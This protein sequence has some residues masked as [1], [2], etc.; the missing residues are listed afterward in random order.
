[1]L[2]SDTAYCREGVSMAEKC[3]ICGKS[4]LLMGGYACELCGKRICKAHPELRS[5]QTMIDKELALHLISIAPPSNRGQS[6]A[7]ITNNGEYAQGV[8]VCPDCLSWMGSVQKSL[9]ANPQSEKSA[10]A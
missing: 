2:I 8:I 5:A 1:M 4:G 3:S 7:R 9:L 6:V 10:L